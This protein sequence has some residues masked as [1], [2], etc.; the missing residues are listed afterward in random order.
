MALIF[1]IKVETQEQLAQLSR[2]VIFV[3]LLIIL[4]YNSFGQAKYL[5]IDSLPE[6]YSVHHY[7][8]ST[9]NLYKV[10]SQVELFNMIYR[11]EVDS[12]RQSNNLILFSVLPD[13]TTNTLWTTIDPD[14]IKQENIVKYYHFRRMYNEIT[15]EN[16]T[17]KQG[18]KTKFFNEYKII[19]K[20]G[21]T[22]FVSNNCLLQFYCI[23]N[24]NAIFNNIFGTI[25]TRQTP[26]RIVDVERI[27]HEEYKELEFPLYTLRDPLK[28]NMFARLRD[29]REYLSEIFTNAKGVSLYK[30]WTYTDWHEH[31]IYYEVERGIDRFV[32][33]PGKGIVGGSFDFYF[34]YHREA[35]GLTVK[36]FI[37]N[38][39][40]EKVMID[41]SIYNSSLD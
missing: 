24:R 29:R 7:T 38:I 10:D 21:D 35:L 3:L 39:R 28:F 4:S 6:Q 2:C 20:R 14:S 22:F 12:S 34:Y 13:F 26:H 33:L 31:R 16:Y 25:N 11:E 40:A 36:D 32:Y 9:K 27:F 41:A 15:L 1:L 18:D 19:V 17:A 5:F 30:F 23:D 37:D 8:L